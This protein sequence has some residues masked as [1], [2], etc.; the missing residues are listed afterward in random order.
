M[1]GVQGLGEGFGFRVSCS[2]FRAVVRVQCSGFRSGFRVYHPGT[3]GPSAQP[4]LGWVPLRACHI[5]G[6][7]R[8]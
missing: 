5:T 3:K 7:P 6:E 4:R 2:G 1:I 8:S